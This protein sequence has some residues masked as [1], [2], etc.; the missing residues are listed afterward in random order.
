VVGGTGGQPVRRLGFAYRTLVEQEPPLLVTISTA[1]L[2]LVALLGDGVHTRGRLRDE[3]RERLRVAKAEKELEA[4]AR[5]TGERLRIAHELHDVM[6]HTITTMTV[7]AGVAADLLDERPDEARDALRSLRASARDA[8]AELRATITVLRVGDDA[9]PRLPAPGL[10]QLE[11][12]VRGVEDAGVRVELIVLGEPRP[13]P[14]AVDLT[15]YRIVQEALTNVLRHAAASRAAVCIHHEPAAVGIQV[16][17][18]GRG[19]SGHEAPGGYG[20]LGLAE[21]VHAIGGR[22][23]TGPRQEGGFRVEA[24]LP[25]AQGQA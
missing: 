4:Q 13:L 19:G 9:A 5:V 3:V 22:M 18:D 16:D 15:A 17:D 23:R 20:L 25:A 11:D 2:V 8:T 10:G 6:A 1:L 7:Q 24:T 14:A 21:R 12:L